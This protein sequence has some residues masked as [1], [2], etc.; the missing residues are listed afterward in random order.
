MNVRF[1][2]L[3][4]V[5]AWRGP[6]EFNV[7]PNQQR[8]HGRLDGFAAG[9][10]ADA[11]SVF[12]WSYHHLSP[13]ACRLFRLLSLQPAADITAAASAC[14]LGAP[15]DETSRLIAELTDTALLTE[16][17]PGQYSFHDL[18]RAYATELL[19][20]TDTDTDRHGALARLLGLDSD[21][22]RAVENGC[23]YGKAHLCRWRTR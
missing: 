7:G 2:V 10:A 5:R 13:Q 9:A 20:S 23:A 21:L 22:T 18:S 6:V 14:L 15:P 4:P 8:T 1:S 19:E 12:S 16:H 3:G 17:R 11:R